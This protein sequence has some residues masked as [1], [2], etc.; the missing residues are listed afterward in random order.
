MDKL[1]E[2]QVVRSE[3]KDLYTYGFQQGRCAEASATV[4][5]IIE[6]VKAN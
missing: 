5:S 6:T 1:I 3:E 2:L 4:I